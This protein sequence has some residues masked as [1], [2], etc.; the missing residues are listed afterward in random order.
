MLDVVDSL[1]G[2][3]SASDIARRREQ[4]VQAAETR[5]E[6][7][8]ATI[9]QAEAVLAQPI[10]DLPALRRAIAERRKALGWTQAE[11]NFRAGLADG[12]WS[13]LECGDK[14]F[15]MISLPLVL[16]TLGVV[17]IIKPKVEGEV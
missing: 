3:T 17:L 1:Q 15:G 13:K 8:T 10:A 9:A 6:R 14:N 7:D 5:A 4:G 12:H 2:A 16:Q 11:A